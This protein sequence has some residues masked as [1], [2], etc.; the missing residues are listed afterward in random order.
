MCGVETHLT[1]N[2]NGE[3]VT[4]SA[5]ALGDGLPQ[6]EGI[7][8][9]KHSLFGAR[10][11]TDCR[12]HPQEDVLK[13]FVKKRCGLRSFATFVEHIFLIASFE[14]AEQVVLQFLWY[15]YNCF[16]QSYKRMV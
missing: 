4:S 9:Q 12:R 10:A 8:I 11:E 6:R 15:D 3:V 1:R 2:F 14:C 7:I 5:A 16:C 13:W